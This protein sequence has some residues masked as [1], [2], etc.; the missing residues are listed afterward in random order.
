MTVAPSYFFFKFCQYFFSFNFF[1]WKNN[2]KLEIIFLFYPHLFFIQI[3]LV[4]L[5]IY[6]YIYINLDDLYFFVIPTLI[7]IFLLLFFYFDKFLKLIF[8]ILSF[9]I[10]LI[11]NQDS[12]LSMCMGFHG[13]WYWKI[14]RDLKVLPVFTLFF[15]LLNQDCIFFI[16]LN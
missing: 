16:S 12:W 2:F 15:M 9:N 4:L 11:R 8:F 7:F 14:N 6:I 13:L 10:K 5:I 1:I 3:F